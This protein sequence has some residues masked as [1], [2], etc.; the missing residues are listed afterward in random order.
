M[1]MGVSTIEEHQEPTDHEIQTK[2]MISGWE[3]IR[4]KIFN[5]VIEGSALPLGEVCQ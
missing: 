4:T 3:E 2:A 1:P 5:A